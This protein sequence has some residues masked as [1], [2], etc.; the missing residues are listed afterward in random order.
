MCIKVGA[1]ANDALKK[2]IV[3]HNIGSILS[4]GA[5][6]LYTAVFLASIAGGLF[7]KRGVGLFSRWF[8]VKLVTKVGYSS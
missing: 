2:I 3:C 5:F 7:G 8:K 1:A 4:E 6:F